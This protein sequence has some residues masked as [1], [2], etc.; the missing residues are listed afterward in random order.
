MKSVERVEDE[1]VTISASASGYNLPGP[2]PLNVIVEEDTIVIIDD[3]SPMLSLDFS[4]SSIA[5]NGG[6]STVTL[7][8]NYSSD[9][10]L[11]VI[12]ANNRTDKVNIIDTIEIPAN[13]TSV[14]FE[15]EA[16]GHNYMDNCPVNAKVH[17]FVL[18][19]IF[20]TQYS[21]D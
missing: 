17:C 7:S 16:L 6:K 8:R 11:T 10:P 14:V 9:L 2:D 13:K 20:I 12:L 1:T 5:E 19:M 21:L 4:R 3:D 15:L 18:G